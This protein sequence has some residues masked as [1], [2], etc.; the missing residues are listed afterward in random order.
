M[1]T[2]W[3]LRNPFDRTRDRVCQCY[4]GNVS[5]ADIA[6]NTPQPF[7]AMRNGMAVLRGMWGEP[8]AQGD[9]V[10]FM[11]L[12]QGGD[13]DG[14]KNPLRTLLMVAVVAFAPTMGATLS[15]TF[16][17]T[18]TFAANMFTGF[19]ALIGLSL[20]N[21]LIPAELAKPT[22]PQMGASLAAPSPTYNLQAQGNTARL[23]AAIPVHYGRCIAYPDFAAQP[24]IEYAGNEQYLYQLLCLGQ[25]EYD[26]EAVR[27]EDTPI[28]NFEEITYEVIAPGGSLTLFPANVATSVEVSGQEMATDVY[29]GGFVA[30]ASGTQ[31]NALGID[32]ILP[33]GLYYFNGS[34]QLEEMSI[35]FVVE[36]RTIDDNGDPTG[37]YT[38]LLTQTYTGRTTTPQRYSERLDVSLDRYEVRV[39]RTDTKQ[40]GSEYGHEIFWGGLRAYF[41]ET[42]NFGDVT[43]IALRMRA[44]NNLSAQASRKINVIS[45]KKVPVYD[46]ADWSAPQASTSIAWAFAD[47]CRN[48]TYGAGLDDAQIDLDALFELDAVWSSREDE[49]NGRFDQALNFWEAIGKIAQA[50][51]AKAYIQGGIVRIVR[52]SAQ[53]V[54]VCL[55]SAGNIVQNTLSIDYLLPNAD[56]ADCVEVS[57]WDNTYFAPR[58]VTCVLDGGTSAKPAKLDYFGVTNRQQAYRE[59]L[60]QAA[61]NVY[62]RRVIK[63]STEMEGF[64]PSIGD[65]IAINDDMPAWG[66]FAEA[67][68][69]D[70]TSKTLTL[71]E[72]LTWASGTHYVGLRHKNGS[73]AT[74]ITVTPGA[75]DN[76]V[77][78]A[79]D[80][81]FTIY[82]GAV[83]ERTHVVFGAGETYRHPAKVT[84]IRPRDLY[85]CEIEAISEDPSVHTAEDGMTVP[86]IQTSQLTTRYTAPVI[87]DLKISSSASD[88]SKALLTWTAAPGADTYQIE[89]AFGFSTTDATLD[90]TRVGE[91]SANNYAVTALYGAQ[92]LIRVRAVGLAIGNWVTLY[93]GSSADY[94]WSA[95]SN[96]MWD[97]DPDTLMWRY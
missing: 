23:D 55:F 8:L 60:Y 26:I 54:P 10:H 15:G 97:A 77:V 6:P 1:I 70:A 25:G 92:T 28:E 68:A 9:V 32:F 17:F 18:S 5:I 86:P 53:T 72:P 21:R 42:R 38:T 91:T 29:L 33:R 30:N 7:I 50:G 79:T 84:S 78:L 96:L 41:P 13:G 93:Y 14:G 85:S 63:F 95:D 57:Y 82:T 87:A 69:Y 62:R 36:A 22:T 90:W 19:S 39:K 12:P 73:L 48:T 64:I 76:Q 31:V 45:T 44:S 34:G 27:I 59:G 37:S 2:V 67:V 11:L 4:D 83:D 49:F 40:T 24:Y 94:M 46:G 66:Q 16:G 75:L 71:S 3:T 43:L 58:R 61:N 56:R 20:V 89:M 35:T 51:R 47:A 88:N 52:D 81:D 80:P 65:L 74:A